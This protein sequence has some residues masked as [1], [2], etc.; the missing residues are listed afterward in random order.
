MYNMILCEENNLYFELNLNFS[1]LKKYAKMLRVEIAMLLKIFLKVIQSQEIT[2]A[3]Q[4]G[5]Y[6]TYVMCLVT[7]LCLTLF[8]PMD[9]TP[10][11]SSVHGDSPGKNTGVGCHNLLQ[12]TFPTQGW[13]PGLLHCRRILYCLSHQGSPLHDL[14][15]YQNQK[16]V[17]A[18]KCVYKSV[19]FLSNVQFCVFT[20][21]KIQNCSIPQ[22]CHPLQSPQPFHLPSLTLYYH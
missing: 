20:T 10:S 21:W 8:D 19:S 6:K 14:V 9:C 11:G 12:G 18:I 15:Q 7:Q 13:N 4:K 3:V 16:I 22:R 1:I 5:P 2:K 17:I